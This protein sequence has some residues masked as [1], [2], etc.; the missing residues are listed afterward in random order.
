MKML[1][2]YAYYA[3]LKDCEIGELMGWIITLLVWEEKG[4]RENV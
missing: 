1:Y 3:D 2:H 4:Q